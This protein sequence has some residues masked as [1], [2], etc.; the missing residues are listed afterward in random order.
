MIKQVQEV[1]QGT[2]NT[3]TYKKRQGKRCGTIHKFRECPAWS[4]T[5]E[6]CGGRNRY[7]SKC[8]TRSVQFVGV[9]NNDSTDDE[10]GFCL[11]DLLSYAQKCEYIDSL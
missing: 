10:G 8:L 7:A 1:E 4:A 2:R 11:F 3:E 9:D 5:C 6:K